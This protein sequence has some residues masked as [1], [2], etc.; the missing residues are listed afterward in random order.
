MRVKLYRYTS[1]Q[2]AAIMSDVL[3]AKA[4]LVGSPTQNCV[5][6]PTM[7]AFMMYLK[8]MKLTDKKAAA[9][10]TYGWAGG[11]EKELEDAITASGMELLP[12]YTCKWRPCR[13]KSRLLKSL[14]MNLLKRLLRPASNPFGL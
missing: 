6:M 3:T 13:K 10:G 11:A 14:A 9:F 12:G 7:G 5:M 1:E 8:G 4:I 2:K